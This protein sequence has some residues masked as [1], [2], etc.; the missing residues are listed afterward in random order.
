MTILMILVTKLI[1]TCKFTLITIKSILF[2]Y[3]ST[4]EEIMARD[5]LL[6]SEFELLMHLRSTEDI[7]IQD[8]ED[9]DEYIRADFNKYIK[10]TKLCK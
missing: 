5:S 8:M 9:I 4:A 2:C 1:I 6:A 3:G 10:I 7:T